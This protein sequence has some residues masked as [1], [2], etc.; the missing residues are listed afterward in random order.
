MRRPPRELPMKTASPISSAV[1]Y[2]HHVAK[3]D[4]QIVVFRIAVVVRLAA[5]ARIDRNH[6]SRRRAIRQS[7]RQRVKIGDGSRQ[8]RQADHRQ[9]RRRARTVFSH[10][11]PQAVLRSNER[12]FSG[13]GEA[14]IIDP[15]DWCGG[16]VHHDFAL[17]SAE[18]QMPCLEALT[19]KVLRRIVIDVSMGRLLVFRFSRDDFPIQFNGLTVDIKVH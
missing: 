15:F 17:T 19:V 5:S 3:L 12:A 7:R 11:Q 10:M 14:A 2:R 8:A 4:R 1:K 16:D 18:R 13:R 6:T 9:S